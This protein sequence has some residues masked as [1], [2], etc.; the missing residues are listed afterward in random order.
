MASKL[1]PRPSMPSPNKYFYT[2]LSEYVLDVLYLPD[3]LEN[4]FI[5]FHLGIYVLVFYWVHFF[6]IYIPSVTLISKCCL[7]TDQ[8]L[9]LH[10]FPHPDTTFVSY[11]L[12]SFFRFSY[13]VFAMLN[14][15]A[16]RYVALLHLLYP[17]RRQIL[18][19]LSAAVDL[20]CIRKRKIYLFH[21]YFTSTRT[22]VPQSLSTHFRFLAAIP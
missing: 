8:H 12:P 15:I 11:I 5:S 19:A 9:L 13:P 17:C 18:G 1:L 21:I 7:H 3:T 14:C 2:K 10:F 16:M 4:F 6:Y 22:M 20:T